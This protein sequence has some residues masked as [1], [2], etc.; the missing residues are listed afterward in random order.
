[1]GHRYLFDILILLHL[2][3]YS[4]MRLLGHILIVKL[5]SILQVPEKE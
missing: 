1:M 3:I 2:D 4:E 5:D